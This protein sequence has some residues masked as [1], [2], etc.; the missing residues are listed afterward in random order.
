[1]N[2]ESFTLLNEARLNAGFLVSEAREFICI[3]KRT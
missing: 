2:K 3:S 1:M